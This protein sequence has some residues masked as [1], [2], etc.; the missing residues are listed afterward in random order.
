M[1][2]MALPSARA[3]S[4]R[5]TPETIWSW[6]TSSWMRPRPADAS[7]F[8]FPDINAGP[9]L[10]FILEDTKKVHKQFGCEDPISKVLVAVQVSRPGHLLM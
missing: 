9:D 8:L 5:Q 3:S 10:L 4:E 7:T 2:N 1:D 6:M